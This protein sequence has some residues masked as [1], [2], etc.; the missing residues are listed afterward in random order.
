MTH[1]RLRA[2]LGPYLEGDLSPAA[3][4]RVGRHLE[5]CAACRAELAALRRTVA[6]V[7]ELPAV[8]TP[9]G[10]AERVV[11]RVEA[12]PRAGLGAWLA[13]HG[14]VVSIAVPAAAALVLAVAFLPRIE[15][16]VRLGPGPD[17]APSEVAETAPAAEPA[18]RLRVAE[19][20]ARPGPP[21]A[22][23]PRA[24][25]FVGPASPLPPRA[26][27]LGGERA[28]SPECARWHAWMVGL[29]M[30][31]PSAFVAEMERVPSEQQERWMLDLS[32]FAADAGAASLLATQL[33][34]SGDP[35]AVRLAPRFERVSVFS[36]RGR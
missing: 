10:L 11:A 4:E 8:D 28:R 35:R 34:A 3:R 9:P 14:G 36:R 30:R 2:Q 12:G 23:P 24:A 26:T 6:L 21:A 19:A 22:R 31:D 17:P 5:D 29:A 18:P 16:T 13:R 33:R 27:C 15:L 7:R 25:A 32:S 1:G 20:S